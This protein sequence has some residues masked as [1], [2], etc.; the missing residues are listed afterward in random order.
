M[1]TPRS[2]FFAPSCLITKIT[3]P[4]HTLSH[5]AL[6]TTPTTMV[7]TRRASVAKEQPMGL[8]DKV[9]SLSSSLCVYAVEESASLCLL[10]QAIVFCMQGG[11]SWDPSTAWRSL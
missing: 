9:R 11:L 4:S 1:S 2:L 10:V 8:V 5:S 7:T 6:T 3:N